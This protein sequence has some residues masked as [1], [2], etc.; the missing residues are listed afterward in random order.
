[1][2]RPYSKRQL[3]L[4]A[5]TLVFAGTLLFIIL[6]PAII[7]L[8]LAWLVVEVLFWMLVASPTAKQ[9]DAQP[10]GGHWPPEAEAHDQTAFNRFLK[11]RASVR[12]RAQGR[13]SHFGVQLCAARM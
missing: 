2:Q 7:P 6:L 10:E 4:G 12:D 11:V 5:V 3:L 1:M 13:R 9:L 8:I